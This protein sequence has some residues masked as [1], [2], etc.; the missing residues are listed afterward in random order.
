MDKKSTD[1]EKFINVGADAATDEDLLSMICGSSKIAAQLMEEAAGS[2]R[3]VV[4][5]SA[6]ELCG[7]KGI[8]RVKASEIAAAF[9]IYRRAQNEVN[10]RPFIHCA[11]D[12]FTSMV[13][14]IGMLSHEEL[15]V[16]YVGVSKRM[17]ARKRISQGGLNGTEAD[18]RIIF[19]YAYALGAQELYLCHNHPS[20]SLAVSDADV[21][22][23]HQIAKACVLLG[24]RLA[25]H[26]VITSSSYMSMRERN[27]I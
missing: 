13:A 2:L 14:D 15:W 3:R 25:D 26:V 8:G 24:F 21:Q 18:R 16:V 12:V 4:T 17:L 11:E 7:I 20:G 10:I 5:M 23:T 22:M 27:L 6:S 9:E 1:R 19:R